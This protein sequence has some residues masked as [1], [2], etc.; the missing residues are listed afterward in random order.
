MR[1]IIA[2]IILSLTS[3]QALGHEMTPTYP[4]MRPSYVDGLYSVNMKLFNRRND[5]TYYDISVFDE[6]WN[7]IPFASKER[8]IKINYLEKKDFEIYIR[9][10]D[11]SEVEYICTTS[12]LLKGDVSAAA[13]NSR[14]CSKIKRD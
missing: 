2:F 12:K 11:H 5:V 1:Y 13:V 6:E 8:L 14:I 10:S 3:A 4:E 9:E 7:N